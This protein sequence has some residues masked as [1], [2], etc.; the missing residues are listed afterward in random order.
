MIL[1]AA[2]APTVE[3]RVFATAGRDKKVNMWTSGVAREGDK[4]SF[5]LECTYSDDSPIT[6]VDFLDRRER[7]TGRLVL[8]VGTELGKITIR[9][10]DRDDLAKPSTLVL[11]QRFVILLVSYLGPRRL[12]SDFQVLPSQSCAA[13]RLAA[14]GERGRRGGS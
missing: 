2:W 4:S 1:D 11:E 13:T 12:T 5:K 14:H 3:S 9:S 7:S 8:A 6:A 10:M